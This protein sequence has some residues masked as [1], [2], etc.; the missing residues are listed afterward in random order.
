MD[1]LQHECG[2]AAIYHLKAPTQ[3][4]LLQSIAPTQTSRLMPRL[5][6][7]LQNRGQLAAGMSTF[8][9]HRGPILDTYKA[10][11]TVIEA[12]RLNQK[13]KYEEIMQEYAGRAAIGH[14]RYAT[15]GPT[16]KSYAQPFERSH[17]NKWKWFAMGFNGQLANYPR[18]KAELLAKS[19]YHLSRNNDT[20]VLKHYIAHELRG[21]VRPTWWNSSAGSRSCLTVLTIWFF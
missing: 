11:G 5:L 7:D 6:L 8:D 15:T 21:E 10:V 13:D 2:I 9:P 18:L 12:F 19:D 3:S 14:V 4:P 20:E 16:T 1:E 17:E